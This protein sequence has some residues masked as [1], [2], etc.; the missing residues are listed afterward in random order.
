[1]TADY[2]GPLMMEPHF[3]RYLDWYAT[4]DVKD[5][6]KGPPEVTQKLLVSLE[7]LIVSQE[8]RLKIAT[9]LL[10]P[11]Q[12][13]TERLKSSPTQKD[14]KRFILELECF[15]GILP[16]EERFTPPVMSLR[17]ILFDLCGILTNRFGVVGAISNEYVGPRPTRFERLLGTDEEEPSSE[18]ETDEPIIQSIMQ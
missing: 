9:S 10:R 5:K 7:K 14:I 18:P 17:K 4:R 3:Q 8:G 16:D 11:A 12:Q 1:M 2:D 6:S 13:K 15:I